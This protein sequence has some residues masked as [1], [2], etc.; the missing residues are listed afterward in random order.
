MVPPMGRIFGTSPVVKE[1]GEP[2]FS[3]LLLAHVIIHLKGALA[4]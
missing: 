2:L 3:S 4:F 1:A